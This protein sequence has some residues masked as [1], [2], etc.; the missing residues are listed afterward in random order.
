MVGPLRWW[1]AAVAISTLAPVAVVAQ[2]AEAALPTIELRITPPLLRPYGTPSICPMLAFPLTEH[3]WVGGG[4][5][6]VQDYDAVLWMS[7]LSGHKPIVM[8]GLRAGGWYRGGAVRQGTSWAAGGLLTFSNPALSL[9]RS[10]SELDNRTSMLDV[11]ADLSGGHVWQGFRLEV[12]ATPAWSYGRIA[13][14]AAGKDESYSGF[15][16][17]VGVALAIL[18]GS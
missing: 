11:A 15:T 2:A 1:L 6:L 12:F 9:T 3:A 7:D 14:P 13:S 5:E 10:P 18:V 16:Y 8:S 17:R 4:Y